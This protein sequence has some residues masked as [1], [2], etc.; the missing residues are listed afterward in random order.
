MS[1]SNLSSLTDP[2]QPTRTIGAEDSSV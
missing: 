1:S 2:Y